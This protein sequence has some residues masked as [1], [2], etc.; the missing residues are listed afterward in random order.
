MTAAAAMA[1]RRPPGWRVDLALTGV[2]FVWGASFLIVKNALGDISTLLF[3]GLRFSAAALMLTAAFGGSAVRGGRWKPSLR[4]GALAGLCL[5]GGYTLQTIGLKFTTV[6]KAGFL[7]GLYIPLVP[8]LGALVYRRAPRAAEAGGVLL[9]AIGMALMTLQ[10]GS[11]RMSA[12]DLLVAASAVIYAIHIL[13]LG[14]FAKDGNVAALAIIQIGIAGLL[15]LATCGWAEPVKF[16]PTRAVW[17][18]LGVTSVLA[19]AMAFS[20]QTWAQQFSAPTRTALIFS[21]EPVFAWLVS[22]VATGET[23]SMRATVGAALILGGILTVEWK[24]SGG[25]RTVVS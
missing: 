17:I 19:T 25:G 20:V 2:A 11:L 8:V 4:G 18:A 1:R 15:A 13:V 5:Y 9:A 22:W 3:L 7:T 24:P 6:S 16:A 12:G 14:H 10:G 21:L 23:L